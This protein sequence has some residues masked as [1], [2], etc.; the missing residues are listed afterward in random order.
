MFSRNR[1]NQYNFNYKVIAED[2]STETGYYFDL[3]D[4]RASCRGKARLSGVRHKIHN[5]KGV[6]IDGAD[7]ELPKAVR[8]V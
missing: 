7:P 6:V 8:A 1:A 4:A 2:H 3:C 5:D